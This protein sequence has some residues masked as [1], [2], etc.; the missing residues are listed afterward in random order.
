MNALLSFNVLLRRPTRS[1]EL[2]VSTMCISTS[3]QLSPDWFSRD[4]V[5]C[6][7]PAL[8]KKIAN[9][10][11]RIPSIW[12]KVR[13]AHHSSLGAHI[14]ASIWSEFS[15]YKRWTF[16]WRTV[17]RVEFWH[18]N[19]KLFHAT[20]AEWSNTAPFHTLTKIYNNHSIPVT[21]RNGPR[22]VKAISQ[23]KMSKLSGLILMSRTACKACETTVRKSWKILG[24]LKFHYSV[25]S[26]IS[27]D[28]KFGEKAVRTRDDFAVGNS[29]S[30]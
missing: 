24:Y 8:Q 17:H 27:D 23:N 2:R 22:V 25:F 14:F 26:I 15:T 13:H 18:E 3:W 6:V 5:D 12:M 10:T 20:Q 19:L 21:H 4:G 11:E 9:Q 28:G 16:I 30:I 29:R 7:I 1:S